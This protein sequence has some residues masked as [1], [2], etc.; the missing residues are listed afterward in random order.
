MVQAHGRQ[1]RL[2]DLAEFR[3]GVSVTRIASVIEHRQG[4]DAE[5][6]MAPQGEFVLKGKF[7]YPGIVLTEGMFYMNPKDQP[8]GPSKAL[9]DSILLEIYDGPT[10]TPTIGPTELTAKNFCSL[11]PSPNALP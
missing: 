7:S 6:R 2:G 10:T 8:H 5:G 11:F 1:D 4:G 9:E 3:P